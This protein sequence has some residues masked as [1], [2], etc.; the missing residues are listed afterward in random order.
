VAEHVEHAAP[1]HAGEHE[2]AHGHEEGHGGG[3]GHGGHEKKHGGDD[4]GGGHGGHGGSWLV[5]YCDMITLLMALFICII[6]FASKEPERYSKKQ[7]SLLYG[8]GGTGIAGLLRQGMEQDSIVW[9]RRPMRARVGT[10]GSEMPPRYS[11]SSLESTAE[12]LR[13][14]DQPAIGTLEDNYGMRVPISLLFSPDAKI[15]PTGQQL[16]SAVAR[17]IRSLPYD[18][19]FQVNNP[20]DVPKAVMLSKFLWEQ[21]GILPSRI[22]VGILEMPGTWSPSVWL[23]FHRKRS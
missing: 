7:D 10:T 8:S 15:S 16:L 3:H 17:N 4:H 5:T 18:I 21:Q 23:T 19:H 22:G 20:S 1:P 11:E 13:Q 2:E 9:R 12:I 6:T 14:L